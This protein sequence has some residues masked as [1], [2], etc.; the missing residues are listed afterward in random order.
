MPFNSA[1]SVAMHENFPTTEPLWTLPY[2]SF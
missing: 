1:A 2:Y